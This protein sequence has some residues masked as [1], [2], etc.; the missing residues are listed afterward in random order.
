[1]TT[2]RID[3]L[4]YLIL[5]DP[6]SNAVN[7]ALIIA[8]D[9]EHM[10]CACIPPPLCR[11][12]S[13][14]GVLVGL[15]FTQ[16]FAAPFNANVLADEIFGPIAPHAGPVGVKRHPRA[17]EDKAL[18]LFHCAAAAVEWCRRYYFGQVA[19]GVHEL[20]QDAEGEV[21]AG[22]VASEDDL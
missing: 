3:R 6:I 11:R 8:R 9:R 21:G 4:T 16:I 14:L 20:G 15:A 2:H 19:R 18:E 17:H 5:A 13:W 12:R 7:Q 22:R 10:L 1:M